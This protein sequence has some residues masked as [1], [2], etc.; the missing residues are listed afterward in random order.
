MMNKILPAGLGMLILFGCGLYVDAQLHQEVV[1][2]ARFLIYAISIAVVSVLF[3]GVWYFLTSARERVL[4]RRAER[5]QRQRDIISNDNGTWLV[6]TGKNG[7]SIRALH[8]DPRAYQNGV[9]SEP[10]AAEYRSWQTWTESRGR[11][12]SAFRDNPQP[13][14]LPA[15][16]IDLMAA[17]DSVQRCLIVG[18]S[19]VGKTTLLQHIISRRLSS[20]EVVVIDPHAYPDKWQGCQ[21]VGVGRDYDKIALTLDAL[22]RVMTKRYDEIGKGLVIE[23][24]HKRLTIV[25]DEWRAIV[26]NCGQTAGDAIGAL[27]TESRKAA[28]SVFVATHSERVKALGID[29]EGDLKDGFAI[30]RLSIIDGQRTATLDTG[31]GEQEARLPGRYVTGNSSGEYSP[32]EP[33]TEEDLT[34]KPTDEEAR[35]LELYDADESKAEICRK[36]WGSVGGKQYKAIDAILDRYR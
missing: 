1:T 16:P 14:L 28:F 13:L 17:L 32:L 9:H 5:Q 10:T 12:P 27:L 26:K 30:V 18:A 24:Q 22:V 3:V 31:S 15:Q 4:L 33:L 8:L 11:R 7:L 36:V 19:D 23:G 20:S 6:E 35:V 29:G 34:P 25:I 21:V 2:L